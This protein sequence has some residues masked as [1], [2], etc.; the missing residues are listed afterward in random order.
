M[1]TAPRVNVHSEPGSPRSASATKDCESSRVSRG[2]DSPARESS[3]TTPVGGSSDHT[4]TSASAS[5]AR[6]SSP[7]AAGTSRT[8]APPPAS[9][10]ETAVTVAW[11]AQDEGTTSTQLPVS[12][13]SSRVSASRFQLSR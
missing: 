3:E 13:G 5:S 6:P 11:S 2:A 10:S 1:A 8:L 9:S 4:P 7:D 12:A